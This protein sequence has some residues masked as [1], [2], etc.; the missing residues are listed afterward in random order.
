ME[1]EERARELL[2]LL[3]MAGMEFGRCGGGKLL[4]LLA[5]GMEVDWRGAGWLLLFVAA[6]ME[7]GRHSSSFP[8]QSMDTHKIY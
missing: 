2:L 6:G 3:V 8:T 1:E 7:V 5:A 4:F